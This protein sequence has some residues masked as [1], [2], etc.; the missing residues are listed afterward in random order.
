M[1]RNWIAVLFLSQLVAATPVND[2]KPCPEGLAYRQLKKEVRK[3]AR[4]DFKKGW[5]LLKAGKVLEAEQYYLAA[6]RK[7][8]LFYGNWGRA[9][10]AWQLGD[11]QRAAQLYRQTFN[12][13]DSLAQFLSDYLTFA[14]EG[15]QDWNLIVELT[16]K[17]Y[18][19]QPSD[20]VLLNLINYAEKFNQKLNAFSV[21]GRFTKQYPQRG[22][23]FL[24]YAV[25]LQDLG[26]KEAAE[27]WALAAA[28][29]T[30]EPYHLKLIVY[31]LVNNGRYLEAARI[32]EELSRI[33]PRSAETY[34]AWGFLEYKQGHYANSAQ[35]Y[36]KALNR[37]YRIP[38]MLMLARLYLYHLNQPA[39]V[40]YYCQ[41]VLQHQRDNTDALYFLAE[42]ARRKG[43]LAAAI[44]YSERILNLLPNHPQ[45][46]YYHG[47]LYYA[48]KNYSQ[49]A[50]FL[51]KAVQSNPEIRRY[52]LVLAKAYAAAG[53]REKAQAT[54]SNY[55]KEPLKELWQEEEMFKESAVQPR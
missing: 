38:T 52:R 29:R 46:L 27:K 2:G 16:Q 49:A 51:E 35:H 7:G 33:A 30:R 55:L 48:A 17:L 32:G 50:L 18:H 43:D 23:A 36:H 12:H 47:K 9:F 20:E 14:A 26:K 4:K 19:V 22:N 24:F 42:N 5:D 21:I 39:K 10:C 1:L 25:M 37:A 34:E 53:M 3:E 41:A 28:K 15:L 40:K 6:V 31:L 8:D 54:Y 44:G 11:L 13:N 45:A